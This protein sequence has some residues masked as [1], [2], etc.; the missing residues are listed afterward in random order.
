VAGGIRREVSHVDLTAERVLPAG[1]CP[2]RAQPS[3]ALNARC[4]ESWQ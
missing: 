3:P 4:D 1:F 2:T